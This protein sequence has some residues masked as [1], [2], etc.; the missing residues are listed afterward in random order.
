MDLK[1][2]LEVCQDNLRRERGPDHPSEQKRRIHPTSG[3]EEGNS[4]SALMEKIVFTDVCGQR[5][6]AKDFVLQDRRRQLKCIREAR[7]SQ[8]LDGSVRFISEIKIHHWMIIEEPDAGEI[9]NDGYLM[10]PQMFRWPD[11]RHH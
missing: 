6:I 3:E 11:S 1:C 4:A 8:E 9:R 7:W 10:L 5:T 2:Y